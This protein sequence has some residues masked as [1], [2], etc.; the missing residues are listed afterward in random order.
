[1]MSRICWTRS[2]GEPERRLVEDEQLR[3]GHQPAGD[4]QHLLFAAGQISGHL[5]A[6]LGEAWEQRHHAVVGGGDGGP[7]AVGEPARGEVLVD[8]HLG[9]DPASLH[10]LLDPAAHDGGGVEPVD[11]LAVERHRALGDLAVVDVEEAGDRPQRR[12][13]AGPVAT[14]QGD[15]LPVRHGH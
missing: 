5:L 9:E 7:V 13:L 15:D 12:G 6:P 10:H 4:R 3:I 8:G 14:E 1:M 2:R 11:A